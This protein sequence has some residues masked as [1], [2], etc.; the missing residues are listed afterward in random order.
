MS[1]GIAQVVQHVRGLELIDI[2]T[3]SLLWGGS[4][5]S[6]LTGPYETGLGDLNPEGG[7]SSGTKLRCYREDFIKRLDSIS[8]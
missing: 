6:S 8:W 7:F 4:P 3:S 5:S 1:R 2:L